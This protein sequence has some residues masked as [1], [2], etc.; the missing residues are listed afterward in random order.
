[1]LTWKVHKCFSRR[2]ARLRQE[3]A[4]AKEAKVSRDGALFKL[5]GLKCWLFCQ[6]Q[7]QRLRHKADEAK[8]GQG[9]VK[10][11]IKPWAKH[12]K[13]SQG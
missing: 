8:A 11:R 1:M 9:K 4:Q 7:W 5:A 13:K 2:L 6:G 10:P 3:R 12:C